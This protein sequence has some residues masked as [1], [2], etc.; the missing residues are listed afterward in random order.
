M[1]RPCVVWFGEALPEAAVNDAVHA[2]SSCDVF[3]T[4][5]TSAVVYPAATLPE[6]ALQVGASV[7]EVN[8]EETPLSS[9]ATFHLRGSAAAILPELVTLYERIHPE[10]TVTAGR[11]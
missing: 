2:A 11:P 9:R 5:G 4:V 7:I 1:L 10:L 8:T 6:L 3:L